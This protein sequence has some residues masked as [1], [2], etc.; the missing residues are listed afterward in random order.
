V[1]GK[2]NHTIG[3]A[4][5]VSTELSINFGSSLAGLAIPVVGSPVVVAARQLVKVAVLMP[6]YRPRLAHLSWTR[7]WPALALG[8]T[9]AVMNRTFY[10]SVHLLGLGIAATIEFLGPFALVLAASRRLVDFAC[11]IAAATGVVLL[12]WSDGELNV[13]GLLYALAAAVCWAAYIL[14]TKRVAMTFPGLEGISVASGV[15]L[16]LVLPVA[17][18]TIPATGISWGMIGVLAAIG[19]LSSAYPYTLDTFILRRLPQR[20][21]SIITS[22]GPVI[23]ALFGALVLGESFSPV[24]LVAIVVVCAAAGTAIATQREQPKSDLELTADAMA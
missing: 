20:L 8:L 19:A 13:P 6:F 2:N 15:S 10:E 1:T 4:A 3:A 23:A 9:V 12:T 17:L 5:Q 24:Q 18:A 22:V 7:I 14:L 21:Y 11:A 16:I